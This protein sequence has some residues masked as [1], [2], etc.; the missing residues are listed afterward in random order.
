MEG[1][2][3]RAQPRGDRGHQEGPPAA[4][5]HERETLLGAHTHRMRPPLSRTG[6]RWTL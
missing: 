4:P 5:G 2:P 6:P 3:A 1:L